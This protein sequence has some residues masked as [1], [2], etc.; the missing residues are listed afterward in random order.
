[1]T[2]LKQ[3]VHVSQPLR[4]RLIRGI[5]K[6]FPCWFISINA[7]VEICRVCVFRFK[8]LSWEEDFHVMMCKRSYIERYMRIQNICTDRIDIWAAHL[9]T[10]VCVSVCIGV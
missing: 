3:E 5:F 9:G 8:K 4:S 10:L 1:M 7:G 2:L 6:Q